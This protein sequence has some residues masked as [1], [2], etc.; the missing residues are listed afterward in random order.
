MFV[1]IAPF[2][3][4]IDA[5]WVQSGAGCLLA[6]TWKEARAKTAFL[7]DRTLNFKPM[8]HWWT[9]TLHGS[10]LQCA[11]PS[12]LF[13]IPETLWNLQSQHYTLRKGTIPLFSF[14]N[15]CNL[16]WFWLNSKWKQCCFFSFMPPP[17]SRKEFQ[18][19]FLWIISDMRDPFQPSL[20]PCPPSS[21][22]SGLH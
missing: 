13:S 19:T 16:W 18:T 14:T 6:N 4:L 3:F 11:M 22:Q 15:V 1:W 12:F 2:R 7:S 10:V 5:Y 21:T 9:Q 20:A 8:S 17:S